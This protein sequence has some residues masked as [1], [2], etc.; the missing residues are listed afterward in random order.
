MIYSIKA[1]EYEVLFLSL[2]QAYVYVL[3]Y[4]R[5]NKTIEI[6]IKKYDFLNFLLVRTFLVDV[7]GWLM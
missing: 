4:G 2:Y 3:I 1:C 5:S 7:I 6:Q